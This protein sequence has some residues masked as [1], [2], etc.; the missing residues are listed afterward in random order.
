MK[1]Y[2][3]YKRYGTRRTLQVYAIALLV[4]VGRLEVEGVENVVDLLGGIIKRL[5]GILTG[6]VGTGVCIAG[7]C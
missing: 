2:Y 7:V 5:L 1:K 4:K 6:S 3:G